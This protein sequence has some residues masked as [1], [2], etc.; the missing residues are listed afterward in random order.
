MN[1]KSKLKIWV[2]QINKPQK[3]KGNVYPRQ[4]IIKEAI[5]ILEKASEKFCELKEQIDY[6]LWGTDRKPY[7]GLAENKQAYTSKYQAEGILGQKLP[8]F[9]NRIIG[10]C[11]LFGRLNVCKSS[12]SIIKKT[13][14]LLRLKNLLAQ[15]S[16]KTKQNCVNLE[17]LNNFYEYC[18][19]QKQKKDNTI[20]IDDL[21]TITIN[22]QITFLKKLGFKIE[23]TKDKKSDEYF[24]KTPIG[25]ENFYIEEIK[26]KDG[27][28][29]LSRFGAELILEILLSGLSPNEYLKNNINKQTFREKFKVTNNIKTGITEEE[30]VKAIIKLGDN[31]ENISIRDDREEIKQLNNIKQKLIDKLIGSITS[32]VVQNRLQHFYNIVKYLDQKFGKPEK[33]ILEFVRDADS[34]F[35]PSKKTKEWDKQ[36]KQ[37]KK[38]NEVILAKLQKENIPITFKTITACKLL[39]QQNETCLYTGQTLTMNDIKA[40]NFEIDHIIPRSRSHC[41]SI[42]NLVICT[43]QANKD[44]AKR[45][46]HQYLNCINQWEDFIERINNNQKIKGKKKDLLL[47]ANEAGYDLIEN[48]NGLCE[49]AHISK[50]AQKIL[51]IH[52]GWELH[53]ET[54]E[55]TNKTTRKIIAT[56]GQTTAQMRNWYGLNRLLHSISKDEYE[57]LSEKEQ[58]D[59]QQ[60]NRSNDK[61]HALDAFCITFEGIK[62]IPIEEKNRSYKENYPQ[63]K[64]I[65]IIEEKLAKLI[66][67]KLKNN[68]ADFMPDDTIYGLKPA[69]KDNT[70]KKDNIQKYDVVKRIELKKLIFTE[71]KKNNINDKKTKQRKEENIDLGLLKIEEQAKQKEDFIQKQINKLK[72]D[73]VK[74]KIKKI[75]D[76]NI[77]NT[78]LN[79]IEISGLESFIRLLNEDKILYTRFQTPVKKVYIKVSEDKESKIRIDKKKKERICIGEYSDYSQ[80]PNTKLENVQ[81]KR[82]KAHKGQILYFDEKNIPRVRPLYGYESKKE[83]I[84]ELKGQNYKLYTKDIFQT[85]CYVFIPEPFMGGTKE[86]EHGIYKLRTIIS[87]GD[88]KLE[89]MNGEELLTSVKNLINAKFEKLR[90]KNYKLK[91]KGASNE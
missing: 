57:K 36:I 45:T 77:Q 20:K 55:E 47:S 66:P 67:L 78:L 80:N 81:L 19:A 14:L 84:E 38:A 74:K 83:V 43:V 53:F 11:R 37:N 22:E 70:N 71:E 54:N 1:T 48:W 76:I 39:E 61:H 68:S 18:L 16:K 52:F 64:L 15:V 65:P 85:G 72:L 29:S 27:R 73:D 41:D 33:V 6:I 9:D 63:E 24:I 75:H 12:N 31:W 79:I 17:N 7:N 34:S 91:Q 59:Y 49:T 89:S 44:K 60:K 4:E 10:K 13:N 62:D 2:C 32:Y 82:T 30:L 8:K 3:F 23:K 25:N 86:Y 69:L 26:F 87:K 46:P 21:H 88:T 42:F 28:A 56:K 35:L 50:L 5:C 40:E 58:K 90:I 51:A